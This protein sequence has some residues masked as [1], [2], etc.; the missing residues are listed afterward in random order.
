MEKEGRR[1][2]IQVSMNVFNYFLPHSPFFSFLFFFFFCS[3][4]IYTAVGWV[5][6]D[7]KKKKDG[8]KKKEGESGGGE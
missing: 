8:E 1:G 3:Q 5:Y 7:G 2:G 6:F 4:V